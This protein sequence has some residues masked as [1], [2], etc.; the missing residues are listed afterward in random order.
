MAYRLLQKGLL[1]CELPEKSVKPYV[2]SRKACRSRTLV[3][4][5]RLSVLSP[6]NLQAVVE[7]IVPDWGI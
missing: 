6:E 3:H 4:Q 1:S 7:F 5:S 2:K